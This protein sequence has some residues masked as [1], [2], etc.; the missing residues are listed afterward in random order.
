MPQRGYSSKPVLPVVVRLLAKD[1]SRSFTVR[2]IADETG[3]P[4]SSVGSAVVIAWN[5]G[6]ID[7]TECSEPQ[8]GHRYGGR[9]AT[10]TKWRIAPGMWLRDIKARC[11]RRAVA[12]V[13]DRQR[14]WQ[15]RKET[16]TRSWAE[17]ALAEA[18]ELVQHRRASVAAGLGTWGCA[19]RGCKSTREVL[20]G[21]AAVWGEAPGGA[22]AAVMAPCEDDDGGDG[23]DGESLDLLTDI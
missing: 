14:Q 7:R 8:Q 18:E 19:C 23:G 4:L 10:Q 1:R 15:Q 6:L 3:A 17:A 13:F 2:Q 22:I 20:T 5:R 12:E 11:G 9:G 21:E 16:A